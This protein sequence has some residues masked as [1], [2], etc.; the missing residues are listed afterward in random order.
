[1]TQHFLGIDVSKHKL[2]LCLIEADSNRQPKRKV[3]PNTEEG[4]TEVIEWLHRHQVKTVHAALEAT[5][6]YGHLIARR[7]HGVGITVSIANPKAV[8]AYGESRM[9]RNKTDS[10]DARMVAEYCRDLKPHPWTPPSEEVEYLQSLVRRTTALEQMI[11]QE[12]NRLETAPSDLAEDI[13]LLIDFLEEQKENLFA[14][15]HAHIERHP[16]LKQERDQLDSIVGIG[17]NTAAIVLAELGDWQQFQSARQLA[18]YAGVTPRQHSSGS[19][20]NGKTR[21][22]KLGNQRLR[23]A[24]FMPAMSLLRWS[25]QIKAWKAELLA[26]NK[27]KFQIVGAVMHKLIRWIYGVLRS[28][29]NFDPSIAFKD[30]ASPVLEANQ[31]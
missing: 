22:S 2:H 19:S 6:T 24:L 8:H 26:R 14:K 27:T 7:L 5:S 28:G 9:Q 17:P 11:T 15:I 4:C 31:A 10:I 3:V 29:T 20:V 30:L 13:Q 23:R 18:A 16:R 25:P 12:K 21:L 1:M